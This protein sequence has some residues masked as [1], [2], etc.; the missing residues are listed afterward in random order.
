MAMN[1]TVF[2]ER[3]VARA[4]KC[5]EHS[6]AYEVMKDIGT[7]GGIYLESLRLW[8]DKFPLSKK[9]KKSLKVRLESCRNED[10]LGAVNELTWWE[11]MQ[12]TDMTVMPI[13]TSRTHRPDF[14]VKAP[15]NFF[16]EI[17]TLNVSDKDKAEFE[18][19]GAVALDHSETVRR[20]LCK[21]TEQ[22]RS[23][24]SYA[25]EQN[26][27]C[28]LVLFDYTTWSAFGTQFFRFL[29]D[30]LLGEEPEFRVL[31]D[32]LSALVYVERKV[33]YGRIGI[34]LDRSAIYYNP[35][36][37]HSLQEVLFPALNQFRHKMI[38]SE[39]KR[40]ES[41]NHWFWLESS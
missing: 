10:H 41:E 37:K 25:A 32:E 27:P 35:N 24:I 18:S 21:M 15:T 17:S 33:S 22:K 31:P 39:P 2:D 26:K 20:I 34:S 40:P 7:T 29:A 19:G 30:F 1:P 3:W 38:T 4:R 13:P 23:Q 16:V 11:F 6:W 8:F 12:Q 28:V 36:A 5:T 14:Q 9:Q